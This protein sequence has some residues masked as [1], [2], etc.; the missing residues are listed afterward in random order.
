MFARGSR[1][2]SLVDVKLRHCAWSLGSVT[3]KHFK[4]S[5]SKLKIVIT[6][7]NQATKGLVRFRVVNA[8]GQRKLV[9]ARV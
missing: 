6:R 9:K 3:A 7:K 2:K 4:K 5:R 8:A 1:I